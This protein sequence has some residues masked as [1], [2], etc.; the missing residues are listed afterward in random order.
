MPLEPRGGA[1]PYLDVVA[2]EGFLKE[3]TSKLRPDEE[4]GL[5]EVGRQGVCRGPEVRASMGIEM[6]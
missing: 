3:V 2:N 4:L 1:S 6:L 5:R